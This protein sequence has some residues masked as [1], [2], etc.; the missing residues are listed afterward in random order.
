[1]TVGFHSTGLAVAPDGSLY[2]EN[3][4]KTAAGNDSVFHYTFTNSGGNLTANFDATKSY[5]GSASNNAQQLR[6]SATT[7]ARMA[8]SI[9]PR[10]AAVA[11]A[12]SASRVDTSTGIYKF[13]T[14]NET[15]SQFIQGFRETT[16]PVGSSGLSAPKYLQFDTNFVDA[17]DA[18]VAPEPGTIALLLAGFAGIGVL[19][20]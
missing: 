1:M 5:I 15:V 11:A 13:D 3:N 7:S 4:D 9:S 16:G 12:A 17:P 18:G 2:V 10:W 6:C 19:E 8:I 20:T 14:S